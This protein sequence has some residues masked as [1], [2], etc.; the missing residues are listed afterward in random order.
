MNRSWGLKT[1]VACLEL[2]ATG[3]LHI[4]AVLLPPPDRPPA[5]VNVTPG[6]QFHPFSLSLLQALEYQLQQG[7]A[8]TAKVDACLMPASARHSYGPEAHCAVGVIRMLQEL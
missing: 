4:H 2:P 5:A 7:I 3:F 1:E 8:D 6:P